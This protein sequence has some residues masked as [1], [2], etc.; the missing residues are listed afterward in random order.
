M[1]AVRDESLGDKD[2]NP[3]GIVLTEAGKN[4]ESSPDSPEVLLN[5]RPIAVALLHTEDVAGRQLL[6]DKIHAVNQLLLVAGTKK[7]VCIP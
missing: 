3:A 7:P 1:A 2:N 6:M 4:P 5:K